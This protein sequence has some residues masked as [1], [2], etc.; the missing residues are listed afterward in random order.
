MC[1]SP[2][3]AQLHSRVA[4]GRRRCKWS[5]RGLSGADTIHSTNHLLLSS[6]TKKKKKKEW[7]RRQIIRHACAFMC[8]GFWGFDNSV[9]AG[10]SNYCS[11][12]GSSKEITHMLT[13]EQFVLYFFFFCEGQQLFRCQDWLHRRQKRNIYSLGLVL[14]FFFMPVCFFLQKWERTS[15]RIYPSGWSALSKTITSTHNR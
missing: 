12:D 8:V 1:C 7:M 2:V 4:M 14:V 5:D 9:D 15:T 11:V 10:C 6:E 3:C 13:L